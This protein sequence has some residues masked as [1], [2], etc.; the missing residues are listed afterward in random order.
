VEGFQ[1]A[2]FANV[3][4]DS[5]NG[6][7]LS[8]FVNVIAKS[9]EAVQI[10]G[11]GNAAGDRLTGIQLAGFGNIAG[12][13]TGGQ[14]A[15]FI[16]L[17][18]QVD[19]FQLGFINYADS[20]SGIPFGFL[21]IVRNGY[22]RFEIGGSD[23]LHINASFR[24]GLAQFY[25]IFS[26]GIHLISPQPVWGIGYGIGSE[27]ILT[28]G[29]TFNAELVHTLL[30]TTNWWRTDSWSA[31]S[32]FRFNFGKTLSEGAV[33]FAG[34]TLNVLV[35]RSTLSG[36]FEIPMISSYHLYR[37]TEGRTDVRLWMGIHAG[38]RFR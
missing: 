25:N 12:S 20:I 18:E 38:L 22:R 1:M 8:G 37:F 7:Q 29:Y 32:Q 35:S 15:G 9:E 21:S 30:H 10:A 31:L 36:E 23:A 4:G 28:E 26:A 6:V 27:S 14:I 19:G 33:F 3:N 34:P 16:N 17:A 24:I 2:G 13:I 11:F 5:F